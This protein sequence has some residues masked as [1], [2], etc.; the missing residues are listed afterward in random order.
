MQQSEYPEFMKLLAG[1]HDFYGK[2]LTE[3]AVSVWWQACKECDLSQVSR[4]FSDHLMDATDGKWMP[5]PADLVRQLKGTKEDRSRLAWAKVLDAAQRVGAYSDVVFDDPAIHACIEDLGG[6]PIVCRTGYDE[7]PHLERRFCDVYRAYSMPGRLERWPTRLVG[8][9]GLENRLKGREVQPPTM[10]GNVDKCRQVLESGTDA[11][12]T[13][14]SAG[15][16]LPAGFAVRQIAH[17]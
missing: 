11:P 17:P 12:R 4:A 3:F 2:D 13:D 1:V 15:T 5:K 6:W 10:I 14:I 9:S 8:Q 16:F 7:L